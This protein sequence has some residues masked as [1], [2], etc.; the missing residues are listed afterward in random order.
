MHH[1]ITIHTI[2]CQGKITACFLTC[3]HLA[4]YMLQSC[5]SLC[6]ILEGLFCHP[7]ILKLWQTFPDSHHSLILPLR[8]HST[9]PR[10]LLH[11]HICSMNEH[12]SGQLHLLPLRSLQVCY[13][14]GIL[15]V[16]E[17]ADQCNMYVSRG[18]IAARSKSNM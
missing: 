15:P 4:V 11:M 9:G 17:T 10:W 5:Y 16:L 1:L 3:S 13:R 2:N 12:E 8:A 18:R 14:I 6:T 7:K